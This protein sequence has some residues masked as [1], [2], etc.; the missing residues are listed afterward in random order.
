VRLGITAEAVADIGLLPGK[1]SGFVDLA[2]QGSVMLPARPFAMVEGGQSMLQLESPLAG[3]IVAQNTAIV[4]D[5]SG[6]HANSECVN[7]SWLVELDIGDGDEIA[8]AFDA[9]EEDGFV[10]RPAATRQQP[11]R[12]PTS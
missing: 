9:L 1:K 2:A 7:S 5:P 8:E 11:P 4:D 3:M 10:E 12:P 6:L